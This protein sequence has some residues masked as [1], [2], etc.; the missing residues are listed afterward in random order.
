MK[1][2]VSTD[3]SLEEDLDTLLMNPTDFNHLHVHPYIATAG[4]DE[5]QIDLR[6]KV[7]PAYIS[8]LARVTLIKPIYESFDLSGSAIVLLSY[9]YPDKA[10]AL[11]FFS[12][13]YKEEDKEKLNNLLTQLAKDFEWRKVNAK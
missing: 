2:I 10:A 12:Q 13:S 3:T 5:V 4:F 8:H 11:R 1:L 7:D 6:D 9:I